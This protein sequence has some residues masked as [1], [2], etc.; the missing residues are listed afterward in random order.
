MARPAKLDIDIYQGDTFELIFRLKTPAGSYVNLT[1]ATAKA[2]VRAT[3]ATTSVL[4]EFTASV[5]TQTGDTLGG[6]KLLLSSAQTT[7]LN[8]NGAW[9]VQVT[10]SD[11]TVKTY[12]AGTVT[13]IK[14][15]TRA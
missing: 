7:L 12:L 11:G 1:G 4:A 10:F 14:E 6:V 2:Q 8:A 3:A 13:L 15:I 9:D 5:L